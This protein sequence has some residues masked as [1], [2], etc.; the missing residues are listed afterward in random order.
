MKR[1][2]GAIIFSTATVGIL[3]QAVNAGGLGGEVLWRFEIP[4]DYAGSFVGVGPDGTVYTTDNLRLYAL[5]PA[6]SL[7]WTMAGAGGGRPITF[8]EDGTIYTSAQAT[9]V[10]AINPDGTLQWEYMPP[11]SVVLHTGPNVGPDGNLY[12]VQEIRAGSGLGAFSVDPDGNL[13]WSNSGDPTIRPADLSNSDVVFG[14][15]RFFAG[16]DFPR[17]HGAVTYAFTFDGDQVGYSGSGDWEIPATSFP[18]M[19]LDGRIAYRYGQVG[20]MAVRQDGSVDWQLPHPGGAAFVVG[21]EVGPDG[22]LYAGNWSGIQLW[23]VNPDGTTRWVR[24]REGNHWLDSISVAPDN[25]VIVATGTPGW[26]RGYDPAD[27]ALLWQ[28]DLP[29]EQD[30][31]QFAQTVRAAFSSDSRTAYITSRFVG[32]GVGHSYLYAIATGEGGCLRSPD[33]RCDGDVDGDG[34][35]N[36]VDSGLV[37]AAFGSADDQDLCNYDIDC[38]GQINPVDSGI[39]QSLFGVCEAPRGV[40]P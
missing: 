7:L 20:V 19:M 29:A 3:S 33:W 37:Q 12:A 40:C 39:V 30:L 26:V 28:V 13:R 6:G 8:G 11:D 2:L 31:G 24:P 36:P 35:V 18:R 4:S 34:Q 16:M 23:A 17:G 27:G 32:G 25:G 22:V 9:G 21:P 1:K 15:G 14:N 5:S 10:R 38:D